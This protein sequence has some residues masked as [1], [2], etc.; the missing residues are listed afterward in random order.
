MVSKVVCNSNIYRVHHFI[1]PIRSCRNCIY[2]SFTFKYFLMTIVCPSCD[3]LHDLGTRCPQCFPSK[4][5]VIL[6][7]VL[8]LPSCKTEEKPVAKVPH[9]LF[10][11]SLALEDYRKN[12][13][14]FTHELIYLIKANM[15]LYTREEA[16]YM[17]KYIGL[18][19][20][21]EALN[22]LDP[23]LWK[24]KKSS[25]DREELFN[26]LLL[27][28]TKEALSNLKKYCR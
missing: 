23:T 22:N 24:N 8:F 27:H 16:V 7:F 2:I 15:T 18:N 25:F 9:Q 1:S 10:L 5:W 20:V 21:D 28:N 11:D 19:H 4:L 17:L 14:I 12:K 6:L 3:T 13:E 26:R